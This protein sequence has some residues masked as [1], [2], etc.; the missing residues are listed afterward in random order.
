MSDVHKYINERQKRDHE[1]AAGFEAGYNDFKVG[2]LL[3]EARLKTGLTQEQLA[4]MV[5]TKKSAISRMENHADNVKLSTIRK[6][7]K[8]LGRVVEVRL[9]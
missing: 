9:V 6:I 7:A 8:A 3:K 4:V 1:F 5:N 2:L